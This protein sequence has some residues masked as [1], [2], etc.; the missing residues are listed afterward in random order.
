[1]D[2]DKRPFYIWMVVL[3]ANIGVALP[4]IIMIGIKPQTADWMFHLS[5]LGIFLIITIVPVLISKS[6]S[7]FKN[8]FG[9]GIP[10]LLLL[11]LPIAVTD[12]KFALGTSSL[13]ISFVK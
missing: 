7:R 2:T 12:V 1:M 11:P 4:L 3:L 8:V 6:N 13:I 10:A 9:Y 5:I